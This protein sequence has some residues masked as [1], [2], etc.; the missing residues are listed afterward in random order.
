MATA[1]I[2]MM[3]V[4]VFFLAT[5]GVVILLDQWRA[6]LYRIGL[7][8]I[9]LLVRYHSGKLDHEQRRVEINN[10]MLGDGR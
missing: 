1:A 10:R 3:C 4:I 9:D 6:L 7:D 8:C 2:V 5:W